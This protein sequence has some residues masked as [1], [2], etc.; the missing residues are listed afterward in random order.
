[1]EAVAESPPEGLLLEEVL[2]RVD[3]FLAGDQA[4]PRPRA[5]GRPPEMLAIEAEALDLADRP[6]CG[7][8]PAAELVDAAIAAR[9]SLR[10]EQRRAVHPM[11][12]LRYRLRRGS[13]GAGSRRAARE[14]SASWRCS[15]RP[16]SR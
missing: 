5:A 4:M 11:R 10:G 16:P 12:V 7:P 8:S 14:S 1:M 6:R 2:A 3:E 13:G 9:P 15:S